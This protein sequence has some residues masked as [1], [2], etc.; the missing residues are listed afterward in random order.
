[1]DFRVCSVH[2]NQLHHQGICA[3]CEAHAIPVSTVDRALKAIQ[4]PSWMRRV[5][6]NVDVKGSAER[7]DALKRMQRWK[8]RVEKKRAAQCV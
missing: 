6:L 2:G 3:S 1:M 8:R 4:I 5:I 7:T